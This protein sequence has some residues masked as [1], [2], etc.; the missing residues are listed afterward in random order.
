MG[1]KFT[2]EAA[3]AMILRKAISGDTCQ[4]VVITSGGNTYVAEVQVP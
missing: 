4:I 3:L 1:G 2:Q